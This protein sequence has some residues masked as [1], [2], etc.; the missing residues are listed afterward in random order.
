MFL[1][2]AEGL[3]YWMY[4]KATESWCCVSC[5]HL[6]TCLG[7]VLENGHLCR[8]RGA[9][10]RRSSEG[11]AWTNTHS[12]R[13]AP[14]EG[15]AEAVGHKDEKKNKKLWWV[16]ERET[17]ICSTRLRNRRNKTQLQFIVLVGAYVGFVFSLCSNVI[18]MLIWNSNSANE[19]TWSFR[20][21]QRTDHMLLFESL[22]GLGRCGGVIT[23]S[24]QSQC[25]VASVSPAAHS[26]GGK[27]R[28][29]SASASFTRHKEET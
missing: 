24:D 21:N 16:T 27:W 29:I 13:P 3:Y 4:Q 14:G 10:R 12:G 11:A 20:G 9:A 18:V 23:Q 8:C 19:R 5:V 2:Q 17:P 7:P 6:W 1:V 22:V 15:R 28:H 26:N 25:E